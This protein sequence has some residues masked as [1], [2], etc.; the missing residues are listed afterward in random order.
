LVDDLKTRGVG[1]RH[2]QSGPHPALVMASMH[3]ICSE[4]RIPQPWMMVAVCP[5]STIADSPQKPTETKR[6]TNVA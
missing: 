3:A 4:F 1:V 5:S 2:Q 6:A